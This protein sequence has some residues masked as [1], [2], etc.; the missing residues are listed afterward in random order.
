MGGLFASC[1]AS[2][3]EGKKGL[4]RAVGGASSGGASDISD[5]A[6]AALQNNI[7]MA[8][9]SELKQS[10]QLSLALK[11]VPKMDATSKSDCFLVLYA[12]VSQKG[13]SQP[14]KQSLGR[15]ETIWDSSDPQF[16]KQFELDYFFEEN[17]R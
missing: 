14:M 10:I 2:A 16:V 8:A 6:L 17:Q 3:G 11:N 4:S 1:T 12:L 7:G 15:T 5:A 9:R 13:R